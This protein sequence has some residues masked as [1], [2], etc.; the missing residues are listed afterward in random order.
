M[1]IER[2]PY[3][4]LPPLP[5]ELLTRVNLDP[6]L[7][8]AL[9]VF[10][11][12]H[13]YSA[14]SGPRAPCAACG[15]GIAA[16]AFVSPLCALSVALF[17]ARVGQHMI[18]VLLA[19]PLIA[20][21][22]PFRAGPRGNGS[23]W[24]SAVLFFV[25]LWFWHMPAP[26]DATFSSTA[27]YWSM[28]VTL[29]GSAILLWRELLQHRSERTAEVLTV[30]ALTSMQMGLLG[31]VLTF[32]G[33]PLYFWHLLTMT[34]VWGLT[35][36]QDQQL[37]GVLM[38][39]PGMLLFLWAALRSL[40]RLWNVLEG[41]KRGSEDSVTSIPLGYLDAAGRRAHVVV[42]LTW[43]TLIVST[44]VCIIIAVLL[45]LAIRRARS[46]GGAEGN[47]RGARGA[48][49]QWSALDNGR[50]APLGGA[51]PDN[52]CL[53]DGGPGGRVRTT[54]S[55]G[56]GIGCHGPPV[57][58]GSFNT[59]RP[60]PDETFTTANEIH[61]PVGIPVLVRL[62]GGDVIHSFWVPK[63]SGKTD[64]IPGQTNLSWMEADQPGSLPRSSAAEYCGFQH[65]FMGF[66]VVADSKAGLRAMARR[67]ASTGRPHRSRRRRRAGWPIVEY[68]C[69]LC[70]RV[71]GTEAEAVSGPD[72][73][74]LM[75]RRTLAAVRLLNNPGNLMGWIQD[76]QGIK[77][78]SEM[79]NQYL[80][81]QQL[82]DVQSYLA[83]LR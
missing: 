25:A 74:H 70:H 11:I 26:Y 64:A 29:F 42:P 15:W 38:W 37:G 40:G 72:L 39:V 81:G 59:T 21:A 43:F 7:I 53:D 32:A 22:W 63:L 67:R 58:V 28:H 1:I 79:P 77:P 36:L 54:E 14:T 33:H 65:A 83:L 49:R 10:G 55:P 82:T 71:R 44:L 3:C 12:G 78:G 24:T 68:R 46:V 9:L 50:T 73:T 75:S 4:G 60:S 20:Y 52:P 31:A 34:T 80:S 61:I 6:V 56:V 27:V 51:S 18:L 69:G 5:G 8:I 62:H 35:P 57:V 19:A 30:G 45:W 13:F 16:A 76:P 41:T 48:R 47:S 17:S 2:L 66:E 23:L